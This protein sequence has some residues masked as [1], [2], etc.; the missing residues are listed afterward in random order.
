VAAPYDECRPARGIC[1]EHRGAGG[2]TAAAVGALT[3]QRLLCGQ[4]TVTTRATR[5]AARPRA[6]HSAA[7]DGAAARRADSAATGTCENA[8]A[9]AAQP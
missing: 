9:L 5:G 7:R 1:G 4:R 8:Q 2:G 3:R 6:E